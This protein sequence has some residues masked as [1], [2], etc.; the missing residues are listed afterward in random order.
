MSQTILI[1]YEVK[2]G[3]FPSKDT[4]ELIP[5]SNRMIK[6]IT[7][8]GADSTHIG[9]DFFEEKIKLADLARY[10]GVREDDNTVNQTLNN[11]I[12]KAVEFS[13]A[14]RNGTLSVVGFKPVN[15]PVK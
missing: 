8:S 11:L 5:Y 13:Y 1:G 10:L 4:G 14:P 6:C 9:F 7:D 3:T 12:H 15:N 2:S